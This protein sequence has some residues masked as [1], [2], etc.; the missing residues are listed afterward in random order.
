MQRKKN[1]KKLSDFRPIS[2]TTSIYKIVVKTLST[3][4]KEVLPN[5][6]SEKQ[7]TFVKGRQITDE[8]LI[9][10]EA[11]DYWKCKKIKGFVF[12]LDIEKAFDKINWN[13][14]NYML[15]KKQFPRKM[16]KID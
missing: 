16:E 15:M 11:I 10:N 1:V 12:K 8:I 14:I 9:A 5:T 4:L 6:I 3:R 7:I 2:L 13:F